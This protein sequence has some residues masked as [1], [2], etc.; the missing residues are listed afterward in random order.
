MTPAYKVALDVSPS[1]SLA[2]KAYIATALE[3]RKVSSVSSKGQHYGSYQTQDT[4]L[5][6]RMVS[7]ASL[8]T[9]ALR[10]TQPWPSLSFL[11]DNTAELPQIKSLLLQSGFIFCEDEQ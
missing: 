4:P 8:L 6:Q 10:G 3:V 1:L 9:K 7:C 2:G 5:R 11:S